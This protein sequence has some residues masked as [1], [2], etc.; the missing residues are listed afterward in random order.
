MLVVVRVDGLA[1]VAKVLCAVHAP[2]PLADDA[3]HAP[4]ADGR[5]VQH[6]LQVLCR[7]RTHR[8]SAHTLS[9][10]EAP[11]TRTFRTLSDV[12]AAWGPRGVPVTGKERRRSDGRLR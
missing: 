9:Q 4:V 3:H 2:E 1:A 8:M 10:Q 7:F 12:G 6:V 11:G 5:V